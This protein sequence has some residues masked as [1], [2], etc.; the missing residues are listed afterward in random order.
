MTLRDCVDQA[1][2]IDDFLVGDNRVSST[3]KVKARNVVD[4]DYIRQVLSRINNET[5]PQYQTRLVGYVNPGNK[6]QPSAGGRGDNESLNLN[7]SRGRVKRRDWS[8]VECYNCHGYGH[9]ARA[10]PERKREDN[11]GPQWQRSNEWKGY[12]QRGNG[13]QAPTGRGPGNRSDQSSWGQNHPQPEE[14]R[15]HDNP[16]EG[17]GQNYQRGGYRG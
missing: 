3:T 12:Y 2:Y 14:N 4:E 1:I 7:S 15:N 9:I 11:R 5:A 17:G 6:E 8:N 10:C 16:R 13:R